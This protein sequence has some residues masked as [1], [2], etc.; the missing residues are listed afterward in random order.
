MSGRTN[1]QGSIGMRETDTKTVAGR[2]QFLKLAGLGAGTAGGAAALA[3]TGEAKA[4][5]AEAAPSSGYRLTD[6]V[7]KAY[8]TARF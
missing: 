7:R 8:E 5:T 3:V 1:L 2:R 6:H 4:A